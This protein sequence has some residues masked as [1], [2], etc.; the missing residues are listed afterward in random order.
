MVRQL[1]RAA[2]AVSIVTLAGGCQPASMFAYVV[3]HV[4]GSCPGY[5]SGYSV[6]ASTGA[7][8]AIAGKP[9]ATGLGPLQDVAVTPSGRF[10][11]VTNYGSG[12]ISG[13]SVD[14][15]TGK[16]TPVPGSP[17]AAGSSVDLG[18]AIDPSGK[19]LYVTLPSTP[20]NSVAGFTIDPSTGAL[21]AI[22]GSPFPA[23]TFPWA[24]AVTPLGG[25]VYVVNSGSD[26][27]SAYSM[28]PTTGALTPVPGSPF[29]TGKLPE[30]VAVDALGGFVYVANTHGNTVSGY[31]VTGAGELTPIPG[32]PFATGLGPVSVAVG[33]EITSTGSTTS[34]ASFVYVAIGGGGVWGYSVNASTGALT[35][36]PG[37]PFATGVDPSGVTV[38]PSGRF[39]YVSNYFSQNVSSYTVDAI[40]G[41][42]T[43]I[44]GKL[45][46]VEG[47]PT[48]VVTRPNP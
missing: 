6:N 34:A 30:S 13:Y 43:P 18:V 19:F 16:L 20:P 33:L 14:A 5:V 8:T 45:P 47:S 15:S 23:G 32:S 2:F 4:C 39:V 36:V 3:S 29:A 31:S 11:Y 24:V 41:A 17:F 38:D 37:S 25:F 48:A 22:P 27:L 7:L 40:S 26:N 10:L 46:A 1:L 28:H 21:T 35:P 9:F 44:P 12:D 42:L